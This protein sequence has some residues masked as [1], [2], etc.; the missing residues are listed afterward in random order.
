[1]ANF[2]P[3]DNHL[4]EY[5]AGTLDWGL[6]IMVSAHLSTC[7]ECRHKVRNLNCVGG[8]M[9]SSSPSSPVDDQSFAKVMERIRAGST[10]AKKQP[11][12]LE[13]DTFTPNNTLPE[14]KMVE[15][16][17]PVIQKLLPQNKGLTWKRVS[18]SLYESQLQT[19]QSKYKICFHKIKRGGKVVEHDHRGIEIT[20]VLKGSF[21]DEKAT[22]IPGDFLIRQPGEVHR[23]IAT[24]NKDCLCIS[25]TDAPVKIT[26]LLGRFINPFL[27]FQTA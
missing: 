12:P 10:T 27:S 5:V 2:H 19:G 24:Q 11:A 18:S 26:G 14:G 1:M 9:I 16:I 15:G 22:Y 3:S 25:L 6:S 21:S 23:P 13:Q 20:L 4:V 7:A 8:A 17:P